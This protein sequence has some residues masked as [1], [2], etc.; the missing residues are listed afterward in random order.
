MSIVYEWSYRK[1]VG[2]AHIY[3]HH[4]HI[5]YKSDCTESSRDHS[6]I[7]SILLIS[8][9][10]Y[11]AFYA[12]VLGAPAVLDI[13]KTTNILYILEKPMHMGQ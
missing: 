4:E 5:H 11:Y 7:D 13:T 6:K 9:I 3:I 12:H 10:L 2:G 8:T 1:S